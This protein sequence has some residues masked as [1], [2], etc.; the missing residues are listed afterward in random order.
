MAVGMIGIARSGS[1]Y[2]TEQAKEACYHIHNALQRI[3]KHGY[4]MRE[5]P[6]QHLAQ[7]QQYRKQCDIALNA[8]R[9][10]FNLFVCQ[11]IVFKESLNLNS[12]CTDIQR[13]L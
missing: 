9:V 5:V 8:Y 10:Y 6:G 13:Y 12:K 4:G 11:K 1:Q 3:C 2:D 7:E